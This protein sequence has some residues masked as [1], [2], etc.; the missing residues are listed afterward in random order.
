M[1]RAA[2]FV[3]LGVLFLGNLATAQVPPSQDA[4]IS[5]AKRTTN[6]GTSGSLA[7]QAGGGITLIQFDL[8]SLPS[9]VT[10]SQLNK[11]TLSLFVTG[12]TTGGTFD[13]YL[14][15]APWSEASVTFNSAP[16]LGTLVVP[17][18]SI[19]ASAKNNFIQLDVT[20]ALKQWISGT[21]N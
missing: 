16:A 3:L 7:V 21:P 6:Y 4:F 1:L 10:S 2:A 9:G 18:V 15:N 14:V 11:G 8:S 13:V 20:S 17:G 19:S 5:P 12:F